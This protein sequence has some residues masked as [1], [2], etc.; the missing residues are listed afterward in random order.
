MQWVLG[1]LIFTIGYEG[2]G[3]MRFVQILKD[4]EVRTL[5][6]CRYNAYSRNPDF[7]K[8]RLA[9]QIAR[10]GIRYEHLRQYGIPSEIRKSGNAIEWYIANV[11][12]KISSSVASS[13]E[14]PVCF[15]C[16]E[17]DINSCHRKVILEAMREQGIDGMDLYPEENKRSA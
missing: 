7:S 2:L 15:L 16:M 12:P 5:L 14:Q 10:E 6:D 4:H 1:T 13:Y 9:S 17:R 11:K 3:I 8:T